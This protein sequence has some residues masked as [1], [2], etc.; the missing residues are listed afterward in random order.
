MEP[1]CPRCGQRYPYGDPRSMV[2]GRQ[3]FDCDVRD[4]DQARLV[5]AAMPS[6]DDC[7]TVKAEDPSG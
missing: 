1:I 3:C 7:V 4:N 2:R 6:R 5:N